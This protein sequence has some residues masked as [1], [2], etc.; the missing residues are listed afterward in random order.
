MSNIEYREST[1]EDILFLAEIRARNSATEEYWYDRI[2]GYLKFTVNPQMAFKPR[3]I[4][5]AHDDNVIVGFI[6]G[7]LSHRFE[8]D[9]ELQWIDVVQEYRKVGIA[10][11]LVK[12]LARWFIDQ[13]SLK[14]CVDPGNDIAINFYKKNGAGFL[15]EHWLFWKNISMIST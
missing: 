5:V 4:Y 15:N 8:C 13:N 7:H 2:S 1:S 6:A 9:G 10:S 12:K 14:I 11:E 3:I